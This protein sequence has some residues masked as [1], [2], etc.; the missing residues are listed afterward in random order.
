[1]R[2]GVASLRHMSICPGVV[3][4]VA[5][6]QVDCAPNAETSTESDHEGLENADSRLE[7]S[8]NC[9]EPNRRF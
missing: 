1:M 8:H 2:F 5:F 6:E 7:K 4:A 3:V 9:I